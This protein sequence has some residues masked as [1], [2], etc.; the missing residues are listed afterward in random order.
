MG[1]SL[2][3]V[4]VGEMCEIDMAWVLGSSKITLITEHSCSPFNRKPVSQIGP[5]LTELE[6]RINMGSSQHS[7]SGGEMCEIDIAW[8]SVSSTIT[9][10]TEHSCSPFNR[11]SQSHKLDHNSRSKRRELILVCLIIR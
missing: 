4:S 7:V 2:H 6:T 3:S 5:Q 8:V 9:L 10:R 1:S 11:I